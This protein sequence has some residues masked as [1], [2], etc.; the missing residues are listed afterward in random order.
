MG[1]S[2]SGRNFVV[3]R[4]REGPGGRRRRQRRRRTEAGRQGRQRAEAT[5]EPARARPLKQRNRRRGHAQN[6]SPLTIRP[7]GCFSC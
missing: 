1:A 3:A 5:A 4:L 7:S 2:Y 6:K